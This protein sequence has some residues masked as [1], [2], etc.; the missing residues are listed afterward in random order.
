M[1]EVPVAVAGRYRLFEPIGHG[2]M[3][4]VWRGHDEVLDRPV[5]VKML[6]DDASE[7]VRDRLWREARAFGR[8]NHPRVAQV[9]DFGSALIDGID[10][11]F[12]VMEYVH[13]ESLSQRI[14]DAALDWPDAVRLTAQLAEGLAAVHACGLVHRDVKPDNVLLTAAG[15]KLVDF[16]ISAPVGADDFEAEGQLLGTPAYVAPER[17]VDAPV[18]PA[19][20]VYALGV[21]LYRCV[22][23]ALP[24]PTDTATGLVDAHL[25]TTAAPLPVA[26]L[27]TAVAAVIRRCLAKEPQDRPAATDLA[28]TL[29]GVAPVLAPV[30][31]APA[32][33]AGGPIP[34]AAA[35]RALPASATQWLPARLATAR[36]HPR[37]MVPIA[38]AVLA[39]L[40]LFAAAWAGGDSS[41]T[42][43]G[44]SP[45]APTPCDATFAVLRDTGRTFAA[46]LTVIN[47]GP[48]TRRWEVTFAF[49]GSQ[50]VSGEDRVTVRPVGAKSY[51]A[52]IS[53]AG[54][55]VTVAG[56]ADLARNQALTVPLNA[57][58]DRINPLP[59]SVALNGTHCATTVLGAVSPSPTPRTTT[60]GH[61]GDEGEDNSGHGPGHGGEG[62]GKDKDNG[63]S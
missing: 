29:A 3:S 32:L 52:D 48:A 30:S 37:R 13:G 20:D 18:G 15:P 43:S 17:L 59:T 33:G 14:D 45:L 12:L 31:P 57:A 35:T 54:Q 23:G 53:Q 24:W 26:G 8:V 51:S 56:T 11:P 25:F 16:G 9:Y 1:S 4:V 47:R 38:A 50:K 61:D 42:D 22:S 44:T 2:G 6:S 19:A 40:L 34:A 28:D 36:R 27:P 10:T 55:Q 7:A 60:G 41:N 21:L 39:P 5:A 46:N 62:K 49:P 63:H 58:R